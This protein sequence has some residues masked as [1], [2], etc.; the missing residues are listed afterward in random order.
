MLQVSTCNTRLDDVLA[1][2]RR[3]SETPDATAFL[4]PGRYPLTYRQL[5]GHVQ[6]SRN[7]LASLGIGPGEVTALVFPSGPELITA[8][9]AVASTG[10]CAPLDPALTESE[11]RFCL[12]RL[13]ART[14]IVP[15]D[16]PGPAARAARSLGMR[17]LTIHVPPDQPAGVFELRD[18]GES[19][20]APGR[21]TDAALLLFTSATTDSPKLVPLTW[22]NLQ[23]MTMHD[24]RALQLTAADR[25]LSLMPLFHL[26]G[27]A[28][29]LTQLSC[30]AALSALPG[31]I[32]PAFRPGSQNCA[33]P[34]LPRALL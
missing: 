33:L 26:H 10:A 12:S 32:Q 16:L 17:V 1:L 5:W 9:L 18:T 20:I 22:W 13:R 31:L 6:T 7:A 11:F 30:G 8:F 4:A 34:G 3:A 19:A 14:L 15:D 29:V 24:S 27:L 23:A 28:T 25:L 21:E 2:D